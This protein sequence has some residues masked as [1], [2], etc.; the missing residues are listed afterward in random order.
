MIKGYN[1][2]GGTMSGELNRGDAKTN[3]GES[4]CGD[5]QGTNC[6]NSEHNCQ[7]CGDKN[8]SPEMTENSSFKRSGVGE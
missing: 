2:D 7:N 5:E 3:C 8:D 4:D 6:E 1:C